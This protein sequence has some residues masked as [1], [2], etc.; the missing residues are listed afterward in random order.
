MS[1]ELRVKQQLSPGMLLKTN[2]PQALYLL[3][4]LSPPDSFGN[5]PLPLD[6]RMML[7][8]S[9]SMWE[10]AVS[11]SPAS[12]MDMLKEAATIAVDRLRV[13][14]AVTIYSF[15]GGVKTVQKTIVIKDPSDYAMIRHN[16]SR[17]KSEGCT[18]LSKVMSK[19]NN[20]KK[21]DGY[22]TRGMIF[23]DGDVNSPDEVR[24]ISAC[25]DLA[26]EGAGKG[27]SL[28]TYGLG[29]T[30]NE[31]FLK[32]LARV[33]GGEFHHVSSGDQMASMFI[34]QMDMMKDVRVTD[35]KFTIDAVPGVR[36]VD[37]SRVIPDV[38]KHQVTSDGYFSGRVPDVDGVR[39]AAL[40][41]MLEVDGGF[42][43]NPVLAYLTITYDLPADG[44]KGAVIKREIR[45]QF[46]DDASLVREDREVVEA[47][48][49]KGAHDLSTLAAAAAATGNL[50]CATKRMRQA[51]SLYSRVGEVDMATRMITLSND[52]Q[53]K[54]GISGQAVNT[55][56]TLTNQGSH[57]IT[58]R[59]TNGGN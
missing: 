23:T 6:L 51:A 5:G 8:R 10:P 29:I 55:R 9:S 25:M 13:N 54:G 19:S 49:L 21:R 35:L 18:N 39:G 33:T 11:G 7:D 53:N 37:V 59:L 4:R 50:G 43:G 27:I 52:V 28:V 15:S 44:I 16:I 48:T 30:Y 20:V 22:V 42:D 14:D 31:N 57:L 41:V 36:M 56:R 26:R 3:I 1:Q 2:G 40:M 34:K 24:E 58:R 12:K 32:D 45:C 46:T 47:V 17:I 38:E